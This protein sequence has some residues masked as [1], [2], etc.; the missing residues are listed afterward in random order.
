MNK[1]VHDK[2]NSKEYDE[3]DDKIQIIDAD[4]KKKSPTKSDV[5]AEE[6]NTN[7]LLVRINLN[8]YRP[9]I[10]KNSRS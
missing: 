4:F 1:A 9:F 3:D 6:A 2:D 7:T 8:P 5:C 10:R